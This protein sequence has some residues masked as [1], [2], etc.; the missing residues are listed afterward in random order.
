[1]SGLAVCNGI[2][3]LIIDDD[4][5]MVKYLHD[6]LEDV[7]FTAIISSNGELGLKEALHRHPKLVL[8]DIS[9]PRINGF[10]VLKW[11]KNDL[12]TK[13]I[14]VI[15]L[16]AHNQIHDVQK[17]MQGGAASYLVKP[18]SAESLV[19]RLLKILNLP[20]KYEP[21]R[22]SELLF[23]SIFDDGR[24]DVS[25]FDLPPFDLKTAL[26]RMNNN[27]QLLQKLIIGFS[28]NFATTTVTLYQY[29]FADALLD[30]EILAH[31]LKG[32]TATLEAHDLSD[33]AYELELACHDGRKE[34]I[35][36]LI[37]ALDAQLQPAL[38]SARTLSSGAVALAPESVIQPSEVL[39]VGTVTRLVGTL[40][41]LLEGN[42]LNAR[43]KFLIFRA[44]MAGRGA[45][46]ELDRMAA[47]LDTL[48]YREARRSLDAV[49]DRVLGS[50]S[51]A[52][53]FKG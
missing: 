27:K 53:A 17:A 7:G 51:R 1:M 45:D 12:R 25:C 47:A 20:G 41:R 48:N 15:M 26:E 22:R 35:P 52:T 29:L 10:D 21:N 2:S 38:E 34:D 40:A 18:V 28:S 6:I 4:E 8:L 9:M 13:N 14:P 30:A 36:F 33:A 44:E 43:K 32:I 37:D 11:L 19:T 42:S 23:S 39:D 50:S 31:K 3:I 49:C 46:H 24:S 5:L 16:T